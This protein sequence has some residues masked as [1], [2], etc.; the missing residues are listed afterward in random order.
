MANRANQIRQSVRNQEAGLSLLELMA[1]LFVMILAGGVVVGA[2]I[3]MTKTQGT[4]L[5]NILGDGELDQT[6]TLRAHQTTH[7]ARPPLAATP[8]IPSYPLWIP[9][10]S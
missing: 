6:L 2:L 4:P 10:K 7:T 9:R 3:G 8:S 1:S 5:L